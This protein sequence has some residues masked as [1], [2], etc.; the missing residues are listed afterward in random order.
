MSNPWFRLYAEFAH[1]PK[2]QMLSE[3]M[4]R[5]YIM[6][7][8]LRCSNVTVTLRDDELAFQLRISDDELALTKAL[9]ITK[10]FVNEDWDLLNWDKRQFT[11]DRDLSGAERQKR[12]REKV[13]NALRNVTVTPPDTDTD[14]DTDK[15]KT[16][17]KTVARGSRLPTD[18]SPDL[19]F[20]SEAGI[21]DCQTEVDKF[22]DYWKSQ[23]GQKGVKTDWP[24][25]WRNWCR[26]AKKPIQ[27]SQGS[28]S[29]TAYQ[30]SMRL[31]WE[32]ATGTSS[33]VI[34][35]TPNF[36]EIA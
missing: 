19:N 16:V 15:K 9:F 17:G 14:T 21:Q 30:R 22:S 10:G 11:S 5:R 28:S 25:T 23:P 13:R 31:R 29:E 33:R 34:D 36:L 6:L 20:A 12:H 4:Q 1:D 2:V 3:T 35:I 7:M 18:F 32:E 27:G 24:A 26:N 8:C